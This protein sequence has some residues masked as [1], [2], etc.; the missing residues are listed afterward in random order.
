LNVILKMKIQKKI[1]NNKSMCNNNLE[2]SNNKGRI[3]LRLND[4]RHRP[5][6]QLR[7]RVF[8]NPSIRR[9]TFFFVLKRNL[10]KTI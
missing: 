10:I 7:E 2:I 3:H 8:S 9:N 6:R 5:F 4:Y 1:N